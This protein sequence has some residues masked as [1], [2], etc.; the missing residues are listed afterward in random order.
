LRPV[1][2]VSPAQILCASRETPL[3]E[4]KTEEP[5]H[6]ID[7]AM[8]QEEAAHVFR[9]YGMSAAPVVDER[10]VLIGEVGV[11]RIIDVIDEEAQEDIMHLGG[12]NDS[13]LYRSPLNAVK[14]RAPWLAINLITTI[15]GALVISAFKDSIQKLSV[16]A[17]LLPIVACLAGNAGTQ[18]LTVAVRA[19]SLRELT[20]ANMGRTLRKELIV[21]FA[22]GAVLAALA[23]G[24]VA[25]IYGDAAL[26]AVFGAAIWI[27][28]GFSGV[29]GAIIPIGLEKCGVDPAIASSVFL[30]AITDVMSFGAFLTGA[31]WLLTPG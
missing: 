20:S 14:S 8:D 26:G 31:Y 10:G 18:A 11:D 16:L 13:D 9:R 4:L 12:V 25:I 27:A 19:L 21:G 23:G 24:A 5:L 15:G 1:G 17:V 22:N 30:M 28:I 6:A 29:I 7:P 2:F 3:S